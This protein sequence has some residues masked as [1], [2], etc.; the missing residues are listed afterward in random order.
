MNRSLR[1][2]CVALCVVSACAPPDPGRA[3]RRVVAYLRI[4]AAEDARPTEGRQLAVLRDGTRSPDA[5]LRQVAVRGLGRLENPELV[6]DIAP[7][8][9]DL[10]PGVRSEAANALAQAVHRADGGAVLPLL[11]ERVG[12]EQDSTVLASLARSIGRSASTARD[13]ADASAALLRISRDGDGDAPVSTLIGV[14]LG[15]ESLVRLGRGQGLTSASAARLSALTETL[16]GVIGNVDGQRL[17]ALAYSV[18]GQARRLDRA[19]VERGL[20]DPEPYVRLTV[21]RH[22]DQ[23]VPTQRAEPIRRL[24]GDPVAAVAIEAVRQIAREP[25]DA[26]YC[27]YLLRGIGE[28]VPAGIRVVA[29]DAL[30]RP[31]PDVLRQVAELARVASMPGAASEDGWQAA[32]HALLSLSTIAPEVA[33]PL[34]PDFARSTNAFVRAYGA[35]AA[36]LLRDAETLR[37]LVRDADPNVR[38]AAIEGL[39]ELRGHT[40][41]ALLVEQLELD[42]PQLIM[43]AARLLEG[44]PSSESALALVSTFER[45]SSAERETWRDPRLALLTRIAELGA[46]SLARRLTPYAADYDAEVSIRVAELLTTWTGNAQ[47]ALRRPLARLDLPSTAEYR[48]LIGARIALHMRTGG[49][50]VI[51]LEPESA[52]T[53][54]AR[55]ARLTSAGHFD[56]LTF[57]RW[58]PNF[59]IQ[60]GSPGA[61][62]Y[63]GDGPYTRDEVGLPPHWRGTVGIST[64]GRD[65]GDGQIFVNLVDNVRLDHDYTIVGHV[66]EGLDV[67]DAVLEGRV[68]ER[69]ELLPPE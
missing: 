30:A 40:V 9:A 33:A 32:A 6:D 28:G 64:R 48:S 5:Y 68:I 46:P 58:A 22:L 36:T 35:R 65:T 57:H 26:T 60:G 44:S 55:F 43:T 31:C 17:R 11:L 4:V 37:V 16:S 2:L 39:F 51:A 34:L 41:D 25:R 21:A 47:T 45:I 29:A 7:M 19:H 69:A 67:V 13:R 27:G 54:V 66:V 3:D 18:L 62:E 20:R 49:T 53:N 42:D 14:A 15:F 1:T 12:I 56:G 50:I 10:H 52:T 38:T 23:L 59:V 63:Q 24:L 8:L 61:N